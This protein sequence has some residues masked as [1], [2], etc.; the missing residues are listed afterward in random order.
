M[1]LGF[2]LGFLVGFLV[3]GIGSV[4]CGSERTGASKNVTVMN[5]DK[6]G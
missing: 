1:L 2:L 3:G 4:G 6:M 5:T